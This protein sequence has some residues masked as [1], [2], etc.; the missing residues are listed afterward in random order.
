MLALVGADFALE[1]LHRI[2]LCVA[3]FVI[4]ALDGGEA[5][6]HPLAGDGMAPFFGGQVP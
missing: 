2:L 6:L 4:P 1:R 3:G 5:K